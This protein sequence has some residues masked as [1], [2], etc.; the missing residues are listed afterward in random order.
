[1]TEIGR[2]ENHEADA[3]P[4]PDSQAKRLA[5]ES[6]AGAIEAE[7]VPPETSEVAFGSLTAL[8]ETF[9]TDVLAVLE[10]GKTNKLRLFYDIFGINLGDATE[11]LAQAYK[12]KL[13]ALR[14]AGIIFYN[15]K[16]NRI[17]KPTATEMEAAASRTSGTI[18][19]E[20]TFKLSDTFETDVVAIITRGEINR[21]RLFY[22]LFKL[23]L[24][25]A[26]QAQHRAFSDGVRKLIESGTILPNPE[27]PHL[28]GLPYS[29]ARGQLTISKSS[30]PPLATPP[31]RG[32]SSH[33][34]P[35]SLE[36]TPEEKLAKKIKK[37]A[38]E[39]PEVGYR[40]TPPLK[41]FRGHN[42]H[43]STSGRRTD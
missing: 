28:L 1:M 20:E 18:A 4:F 10:G 8:P 16:S 29:Q 6:L 17:R 41:T 7:K 12:A 36:M 37:L 9:E 24:E 11:E 42:D 33:P 23:N 27:N 39:P 5:R 31:R 2:K 38:D 32:I 43:I 30:S 26:S 19:K 34:E 14:E 15:R 25:D 40:R 13:L 3:A 35:P 22:E 21:R